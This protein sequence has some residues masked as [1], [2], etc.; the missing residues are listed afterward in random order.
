MIANLK[1]SMTVAVAL[2]IFS[3]GAHSAESQSDIVQAV[4]ADPAALDLAAL[5]RLRDPFWPIG[6]T[7]PPVEDTRNSQPTTQLKG[8]VR[9]EEATRM[10]EP[11]ALTQLPSGQYLAVLKGIGVVEVGDNVAVK[12]GG[13]V[14]RWE[15]KSITSEG[16][17]PQRLGVSAP[18]GN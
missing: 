4:S 2:G 10:L 14:Y 16:I 5:S 7:P 15:I 6:W 13:L 1:T 9:W 17:V 8:P 11:T 18:R 12:Y 3:L